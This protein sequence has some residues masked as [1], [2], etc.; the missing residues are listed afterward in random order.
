MAL[1]LPALVI[2]DDDIKAI[3]PVINILPITSFKE[4]LRI[5]PNEAKAIKLINSPNDPHLKYNGS[6][7]Y[8]PQF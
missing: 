5:Y 1:T 2:S 8:L 7:Q 4:G 3:L 6:S